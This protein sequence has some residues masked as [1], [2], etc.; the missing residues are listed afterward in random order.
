M[1]PGSLARGETSSA[2]SQASSLSP[3]GN[4]AQPR[5]ALADSRLFRDGIRKRLR[6]RRS[7]FANDGASRRRVQIA[8]PIYQGCSINSRVREAITTDRARRTRK[9]LRTAEF[10]ARQAFSALRAARRRCRRSGSAV[11][12]QR[13]PPSPPCQ[14][15]AF[16]PA[17][18]ERARSFPSRPRPRAVENNYLL[19]VDMEGRCISPKRHRRRNQVRPRE[20]NA[21]ENESSPETVHV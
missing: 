8:G 17:L 1:A 7:R 12:T 15:G 3:A 10:N 6:P 13:P 18:P 20:F 14:K 4:R 21:T 5:R 11:S 19:P 2:V 9:R 16:A